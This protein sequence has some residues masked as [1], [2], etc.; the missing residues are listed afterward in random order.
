MKQT[1]SFDVLHY[2][3]RKAFMS[4]KVQ[5]NKKTN[6]IDSQVTSLLI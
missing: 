2:E 3:Y 1:P 5:F 4:S 6:S